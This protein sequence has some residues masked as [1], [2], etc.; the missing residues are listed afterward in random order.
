MYGVLGTTQDLVLRDR[1]LLEAPFAENHT[2]AA[3]AEPVGV[4]QAPAP[5]TPRRK[6]HRRASRR[7]EKPSSP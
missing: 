6:Y 1:G 7:R 5:D 4:P 2:M 3:P